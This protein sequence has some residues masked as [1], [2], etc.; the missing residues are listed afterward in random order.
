MYYS[1]TKQDEFLDI[2]VFKN[3]QNGFFLDIGAHDGITL[4]NTYFF[5][6][7]RNWKGVCIEPLPEIFSK[8]SENRN[9]NLVNGCIGKENGEE[10]FIMITGYSEMLS[11][12]ARNYNLEHLNRID[13]EISKYGGSK[14]IISVKSY[15][16][17]SLLNDLGVKNVDYCSIDV[18]GSEYEIIQTF[19]FSK[20]NVSVF[21]IENNYNDKNLRNYLKKNGYILFDR[22]G[23][24]DIFLK[25]S[26]FP[27]VNSRLGFGSFFIKKIKNLF[28]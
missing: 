20:V 28:K 21:S 15:N 9:C 22:L 17:N 5:E 14:E 13:N 1:Q 19:D 6:K 8:L 10:K 16:I 2:E 3:K 24:D 11:G 25:K 23:D 27:S 26:I 12:L 18:E 4:S 7:N